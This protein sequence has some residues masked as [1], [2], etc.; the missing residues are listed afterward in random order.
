MT[1]TPWDRTPHPTGHYFGSG[2]RVASFWS[3]LN[4]SFPEQRVMGKNG[5][6]AFS[7]LVPTEW[8]FSLHHSQQTFPH[9]FNSA[10]EV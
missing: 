7:H 1:A 3:R 9:E 6:L 8:K 4:L 5:I 10:R 2:D